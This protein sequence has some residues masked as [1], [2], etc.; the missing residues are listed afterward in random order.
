MSPHHA[1][2][3][4]GNVCFKRIIGNSLNIHTK[5]VI[6]IQFCNFIIKNIKK[7]RGMNRQY[8]DATYDIIFQVKPHYQKT[9]KYFNKLISLIKPL[10]NV[11]IV[12]ST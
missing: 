11:Y 10:S 9:V 7:R 12:I 3:V 4:F 6:E 2:T 5:N 8:V 1:L